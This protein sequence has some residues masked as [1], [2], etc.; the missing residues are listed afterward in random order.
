MAG[1]DQEVLTIEEL[2]HQMGHIAPETTKQMV[3]SRAVNAINIE[4]LV[5][6]EIQQ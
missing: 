1:E 5:A 4:L 6:S 2:H 3:S